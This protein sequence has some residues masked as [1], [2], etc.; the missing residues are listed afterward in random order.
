MGL[1]PISGHNVPT[2]PYSPPHPPHVTSLYTPP[3]SCYWS[4]V[5]CP[6]PCALSLVGPSRCSTLCSP[7]LGAD[8]S[9]RG[10]GG[11][12]RGG[13]GS[14]G[15]RSGR[16]GGVVATALRQRQRG[17]AGAG[18]GDRV[19]WV[20]TI[21]RQCHVGGD[22]GDSGILGGGGTQ[23]RYGGGRTVPIW[24]GG[25]RCRYGDA[26]PPPPPHPP[27]CQTPPL[28]SP[29]QVPPIPTSHP[30]APPSDPRA[31]PSTTIDPPAPPLLPPETPPRPH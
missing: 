14:G 16:G 8:Q 18:E 2:T 5:L 4:A 6:A 17:G 22:I 9:V 12:G 23:C 29:P 7:A 10:G 3:P 20:G 30:S 15:R 13:G 21:R 27:S 19:T 11:A 25:A 31:P 1:G 28:F 24:G 26:P